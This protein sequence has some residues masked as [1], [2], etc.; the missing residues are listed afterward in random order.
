MIPHKS[1]AVQ[2]IE[3]VNVSVN[4]FSAYG[5]ANSVRIFKI[6]S[7]SGR[8]A[9]THQILSRTHDLPHACRLSGVLR[10][11]RRKTFGRI[12]G[13]RAIIADPLKQSNRG[14]MGPESGLLTRCYWVTFGGNFLEEWC[15]TIASLALGIQLT[16]ALHDI[17]ISSNYIFVKKQHP[18][19]CQ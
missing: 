19:G 18:T 17:C 6:K 3:H 10:T 2:S 8:E 14:A 11:Q 7:G 13:P 12:Y 9:G 16:S 4:N 1:S 5:S 15:N